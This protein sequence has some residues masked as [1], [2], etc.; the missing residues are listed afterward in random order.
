MVPAP[1]QV[2][3][4]HNAVGVAESGLSR[5][6]ERRRMM[7]GPSGSAFRHPQALVQAPSRAREFARPAAPERQQIIAGRGQ[8]DGAQAIDPDGRIPQVAQGCAKPRD[9]RGGVKCD[10]QVRGKSGA[11]IGEL[12]ARFACHDLGRD[13][14]QLA[15]EAAIGST[16]GQ[17]RSTGE[18]MPALWEQIEGL[19]GV[20]HAMG[21][22]AVEKARVN[23]RCGARR[24]GRA[25]VVQVRASG[26][27][28]D[29]QALAAALQSQALS[30]GARR[31]AA[32]MIGLQESPRLAISPLVTFRCAVGP[33]L[34]SD[35][36]GPW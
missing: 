2:H 13:D 6:Q 23:R 30:H 4:Q 16:E 10:L 9:T 7:R 22:R 29:N 35:P 19:A 25:P 8:G 15:D 18:P 32:S 31:S 36:A 17:R 5:D 20:E 27:Q 11:S 3:P 21:R 33:G 14:L 12:K 24:Q 1:G 28:S 34:V 26:A